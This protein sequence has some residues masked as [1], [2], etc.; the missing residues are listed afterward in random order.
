MKNNFIKFFLSM[1]NKNKNKISIIGRGPSAR[2]F[3]NRNVLTIG[4]N[5]KEINNI[6]FNYILTKKKL[7]C[8]R[9]NTFVNIDNFF[10]Y[11]IGSVPFSL[12]NLLEFLNSFN[13]YMHVKMYGFDFKKFSNDDDIYKEIRIKKDTES[14]QENI[15]INTQLFAFNTYKKKYHNLNIY[16]FGFDFYSDFEKQAKPKSLEIISEFTTNHQGNTEKL[17][18]LMKSCIDAKC[19]IIKFQRRDVGNF[20]DKKTLEKKY[21][22]PISKNFYQ[23]RKNLEFNEEQLD[24]ISYYKKKFD[25]K[26]IFSALDVKSYL[27]LKQRKFKYFKIPSTIS[28]HKKFINFLANERNQLTYISTG[29]TDQKYVNY[30]LN[31][32]KNQKIV[33]MHAVS[34]YPTKFENI[35]LNIVSKYKE[36]AEN[37]NK[38]RVG[39][40][41]HDIGFLGSM[42]AV[43]A[44]ATVIEKHIKIGHTPWMH[45]D[46]TAID[47]KLEL[48]LFIENLNKTFVSLGDKKKK[49]Y[50]FEHHKYKNL[51]K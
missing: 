49:V 47:A 16:R 34:S 20:Y 1:I 33:L 15:D 46:D 30:I 48:P 4:V 17:D 35:N 26:V 45:F 38:I 11:K 9:D 8:L 40:S 50:N 5:I 29:M 10:D 18:I 12:L 3:S 41:S 7:I 24:L 37:N 25:L 13:T 28:E 36:L 6:N 22:T 23:Y 43:A 42:L 44:G 2:F 31:K 27:E 39:Y 51:K 32:F 19:K 21:I 14:I